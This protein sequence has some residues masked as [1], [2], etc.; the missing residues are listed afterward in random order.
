MFLKRSLKALT[1]RRRPNAE[2]APRSRRRLWKMSRN[3]WLL[4]PLLLMAL[5]GCGGAAS[6][7]GKTGEVTQV[8][9]N[10]RI[11][12]VIGAPLFGDWGRLLFPVNPGYWGGDT[13]GSL[14]LAWY[15]HIRPARTV[16]IA[17]RLSGKGRC[18]EDF[19]GRLAAGGLMD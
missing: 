5:P 3:G 6:D 19:S 1:E 14:S 18:A 13:L 7:A 9:E 11:L 16:G 8:T 4:L 12:D 2:D 17:R 15:S 10:T